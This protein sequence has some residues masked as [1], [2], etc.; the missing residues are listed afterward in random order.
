M[1]LIPEDV[2]LKDSFTFA[3]GD[4]VQREVQ[5]KCEI[6]LGDVH[7]MYL[8]DKKRVL[9]IRCP[10]EGYCRDDGRKCKNSTMDQLLVYSLGMPTEEN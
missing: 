2:Y 5:N 9:T 1:Y 3:Y 10:E 8:S 7:S 4:L 6:L